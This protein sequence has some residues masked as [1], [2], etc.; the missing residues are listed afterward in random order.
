MRYFF[1]VQERFF[2]RDT[3][4]LFFQSVDHVKREAFQRAS[5][6]A[7]HIDNLDSVGAI[8]ITVRDNANA[9]VM[10]VRLVCGI[11]VT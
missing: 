10:T 3:V 11:E 6:F 7:S 5:E 8:V 9:I 1:D 4:G 2:T